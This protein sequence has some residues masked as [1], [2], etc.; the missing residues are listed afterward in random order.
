MSNQRLEKQVR[1]ILEIDKLKH[2]MRQNYLA[3]GTR[4]ENDAEHSWHLAVMVVLLAEHSSYKNL[5]I[6]K[7]IKMVLIH[8]LV[9]LYVGDTYCYDV[10]ANIGKYEREKESA[11]KVFGL[12]PSDQAKEFTALWEE[13]EERKTPEANFSA[14]M[15][16][17][18]PLLLNYTS[19][20]KSWIEHDIPQSKVLERAKPIKESSAIIGDYMDSLIK[21]AADRGYLK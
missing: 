8:D 5:D 12:L 21:D 10:K 14:G 17:F 7:V 11:K 1:F 2:I 18:Q 20:G 4:K 15:D 16:R 6:S 19:N 3:D 13:F 9:E